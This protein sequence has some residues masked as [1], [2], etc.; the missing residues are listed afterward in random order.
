MNGLGPLEAAIMDV[1]W[2]GAEPLRVR[3]VVDRLGPQRTPAYTTVMT[4]LD[5]LHRKGWVVR[6]LHGKAYLYQPVYS[7]EEATARAMRQLLDAALDPEAVLLHF[8]RAA[9]EREVEAL[10]KALSRRAG[11]R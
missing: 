1:L 5:N 11:R 8:A 3:Q 9:S 4:V 2:R 6:A 7:R 10:R